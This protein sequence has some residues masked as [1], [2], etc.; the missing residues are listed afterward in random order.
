MINTFSDKNIHEYICHYID[1][2]LEDETEKVFVGYI[3]SNEELK[4][5]IG[6]A[7]DGQKSLQMLPLADY[8]GD[9]INDLRPRLS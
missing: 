6:L 8:P 7:K 1:G 2:T 5:F 4:K 3:E 9:L